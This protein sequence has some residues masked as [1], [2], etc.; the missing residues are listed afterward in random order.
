MKIIIRDKHDVR[1]MRIVR[2]VWR[3]R[4]DDGRHE[5]ELHRR[6]DDDASR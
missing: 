3:D 2:F 6:D 4:V 1:V 5:L